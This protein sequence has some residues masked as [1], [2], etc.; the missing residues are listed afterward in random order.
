[1][2]EALARVRNDPAMTFAG[3]PGSSG[4]GLIGNLTK[5]A[6]ALKPRAYLGAALAMVLVGIGINALVMQHGRHPAPLFSP[7]P[8]PPPIAQ[9]API[10]AAPPAPRVAVESPP[11][12]PP[13][14]AAEVVVDGGSPLRTSDP[15]AQLLKD[16]PRPDASRLILA[17]QT[18]LAKLGYPVKPDG[19]E[20]AATQQALREFERAHNLPE[21]TEITPRL[22]RQLVQAERAG[23]R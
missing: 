1:M 2:I 19:A 21:S 5:R 3:K 9:S 22:V 20:G 23:T 16:E 15:I 6:R 7:A 10:A 4:R 17:A 12:P 8:T 14:R 11:T 13:A 18:A